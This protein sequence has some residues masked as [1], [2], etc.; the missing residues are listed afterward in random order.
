MQAPEPPRPAL[1]RWGTPPC[2]ARRGYYTYTGYGGGYS[3][4]MH[5]ITL[6]NNYLAISLVPGYTYP[7]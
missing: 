2:R 4:S 5:P 3:S 7:Q 6:K 1:S